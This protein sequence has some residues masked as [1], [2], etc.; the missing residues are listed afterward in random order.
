MYDQTYIILLE[1]EIGYACST[2]MK[3]CECKA[4]I[5]YSVE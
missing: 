5:D 1:L 4:T 3:L 2:D